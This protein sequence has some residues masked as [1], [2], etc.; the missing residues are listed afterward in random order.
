MSPSRDRSDT[1]DRLSELQL[2]TELDQIDGELQLGRHAQL[3]GG[4]EALAAAHP[5]QERLAA[6]L[7]VALYRS[8]RQADA[9]DV[10]RTVR[11]RLDDELGLQPGQ[12][13][14]D[15]EAAILRQDERL[16]APA[17]EA[18]PEQPPAPEDAEQERGPRAT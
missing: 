4:L 18:S 2:A 14:R 3:V 10:Y 1:V 5:Y 16:A 6:Q 11:G 9:L 7:M 12:E 13:F 8:G 15:L 17:P